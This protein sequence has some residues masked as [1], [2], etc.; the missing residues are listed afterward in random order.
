LDL[1]RAPRY[2]EALATTSEDLPMHLAA[3]DLICPIC[4]PWMVPQGRLG[5]S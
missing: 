5:R 1:T 2:R 4:S 3:L